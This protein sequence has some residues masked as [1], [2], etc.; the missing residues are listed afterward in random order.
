MIFG[1]LLLKLFDLCAAVIPEK[2]LI[3]GVCKN[4]EKAIPNTVQSA[5]E[6]GAKFLDYRVIIYE[7]NSRDKTKQLFQEWA[8]KDPHV[9][10]L[11]EHISR[12]KSASQFTMK[13]RNR[14][15]KIAM[16]RNKV[17]DIAMQHQFDDYRYVI[18]VDLDFLNPWDIPNI[19]DT[20]LHPE[21]D[22]DAVLA[23]GA[24]DL[25]AFRD[26][27]FPIGFE[28]IGEKYWHHLPRMRAQFSLDP[29][30]PW[31]RVYSAFGGL[32]IYQRKSIEGCR[33][34]GV[35]TKDLEKNVTTWL[36]KAYRAKKE[37]CFLDEYKHLLSNA[38]IIDLNKE[39]LSDREKFP[40]EVG[41][42]LQNKNGIGH[43]VWFSCT[44]NRTL[45]WTCEHIPFHASMIVRGHDKI[46]VNPRM[47]S[48][49]P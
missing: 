37:V 4:V 47:I 6:L 48:E 35:V 21:Q 40:N 34:S 18:W 15:E 17:L 8:K 25:F 36:E 11:S 26:P 24:Y 14:T 20:I 10:F 2:V 27:E 32:G 28:L 3:C 12:K 16:A 42:R 44:K 38:Q 1:C 30:G 39:Y 9:I 33:Y 45:P 23:N 22:W 46:F 5:T 31:R 13:V 43:L 7:N 49:H 41:M 19:I 29:K